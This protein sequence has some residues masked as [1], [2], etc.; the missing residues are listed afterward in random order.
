MPFPI[1]A[2]HQR[3]RRC[4]AYNGGVADAF[5]ETR[6]TRI[7]AARDRPELRRRVLDELVTARWQPLYVHLRR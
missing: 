7:V 4:R 2:R 1:A 3:W 5:P 6:W